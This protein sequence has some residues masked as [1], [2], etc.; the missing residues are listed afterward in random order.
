M[1]LKRVIPW[2]AA[3]LALGGAAMATLPQKPV[4]GFDLNAFARL[5]VLEGGRI[6][7]IDSVAR[8]SLLLIRGKQSV[9]LDGRSVGPDEWLLDVMFRPAI[10]ETQLIFNVD[11]PDV[12]GL[13]ERQQ[14]S[15]RYLSYKD[16]EPH[17]AELQKQGQAAHVI[18]A[19][20][21]TPFQSAVSN[22]YDRLF[23]YYRLSSTVR[24]GNTG[25]NELI[26]SRG[27]AGAAE[28]AQELSGLAV[29]RPL[30]PRAGEPA[31]AWKNVGEALAIGGTGTVDPRLTALA[32]IGTAWIERDSATF[33]TAVAD[34]AV[35][36]SA[37]PKTLRR[38]GEEAIFNRAEPFYLGMVIYVLAL[39]AVFFSWLWQP[40]LMR[41][42]G[43]ALLVSGAI[44]HTTGLI[45]RMVL[46]GRPPVTNLYSSAVFVGWGVVILGM[47]FESIYR[48][49]IGTGVASAVGFTTLLIAHHLA[50][51]GDTMEMMRAVRTP[52]SGW[53]RT[54]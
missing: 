7:P 11:N 27:E 14:T 13:L 30:P 33:N 8:N 47:I 50:A 32:K 1:N 2:L 25:L 43:F 24:T 35:A 20:K 21:R 37:N 40:E 4:G 46:Q 48:R 3:V 53:R 15:S 22:L 34:A 38:A 51:D 29:F 5:P 39:L 45:A 52:T 31:D 16:L 36:A 44:V 28:R 6:K 19:K 10:A 54:S 49:G 26:A 42:T 18:D 41:K 9:P 12:L 17:L 23:L